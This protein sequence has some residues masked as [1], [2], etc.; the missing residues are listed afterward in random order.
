VT[1]GP[2]VP[3]PWTPAPP[4]PAT[5][6]PASPGSDPRT[7][8][9]VVPPAGPPAPGTP[10]TPGASPPY[11][12]GYPP[13]GYPPYGYGYPPPG[14]TPSPG[15]IPPGYQA[16]AVGS[17][18]LA[19]R[20]ESYALPSLPPRRRYS[21][22]L[23]AGGVVAVGVGM[24]L[25]LIGS[26]LV[27]SAADRINIYCDT[28]S[29]PCAYKDDGPRLTAGAL[30]MA[31]GA[32]VGVAGI[33][34]WLVGSRYVAIPDGEHKAARWPELRLGVGTAAVTYRF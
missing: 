10:A 26:Y 12:Y 33:P 22:S 16:G 34:M 9:H 15:E 13:Y 14:W 21:T 19:R 4:P 1:P 6:A 27:A 11:G 29:V 20:E 30:M 5:P 8:G 31:G 23:F 18:Q 17:P 7:P 24:S 3:V 2:P 28:P 25:V 32:L